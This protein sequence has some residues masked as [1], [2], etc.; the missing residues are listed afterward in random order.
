MSP[1][2]KY[3]KGLI[4]LVLAFILIIIAYEQM[5]GFR[6]VSVSLEDCSDLELVGIEFRGSPQDEGLS[7]SF[8]AVETAKAA[9]PG[10]VLHTVYYTEPKGKR[11]TLHVFVGFQKA[12]PQTLGLDMQ[13]KRIACERAVVA[14]ISAHRFVMPSPQRVKREIVAFAAAK[15]L[16]V[17]GVFVDKLLDAS[18]VE[19]WA[20]IITD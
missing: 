6:P 14:R 16:T 1:M 20:P 15:G 7:T 8:R 19:V 12:D 11:D 13:E 18:N 17:Q 2:N 3:L 5:G 4:V 10:S 9:I